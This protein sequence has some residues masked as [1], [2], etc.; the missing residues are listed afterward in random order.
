[1]NS[2]NATTNNNYHLTGTANADLCSR[3]SDYSFGDGTIFA[4]RPLHRPTF[5][6]V[7]AQQRD[8]TSK[9]SAE[10][11]S[12]YDA[13]RSKFYKNFVKDAKIV[14]RCNFSFNL[15]D[16][17]FNSLRLPFKEFSTG[18]ILLNDGSM[19]PTR[20]TFRYST[21]RGGHHNCLKGL[22]GTKE[23]QAYQICCQLYDSFNVGFQADKETSEGQMTQESVK[24]G[25][26][27]ITRDE[28]EETSGATTDPLRILGDLCNTEEDYTFPQM[29]DRFQLLDNFKVN[30]SK[31]NKVY[32]L[33]NALY[34]TDYA[35]NI[36]PFRQFIY[37]DLDIEIRV[38]VNAPK[39][40]C[41]KLII[42]S[43][44]DPYEN[45][46]DLSCTP[47][48]MLQRD[49]VIIDLSGNNQAVLR[50]PNQYRRS[51]VRTYRHTGSNTG[52]ST[53]EYASLQISSLS[54]YNSTTGQPTNVPVQVF[55]RFLKCDFAAM[56][57]GVEVKPQMDVVGDLISLGTTLFPEAKP[58][59][60]ILK[61]TG[62]IKNHDKPYL[63]NTNCVVP[64]PR[65]NFTAGKGVSD[66]IPLFLNPACTVT[67]L[68]DYQNSADPESVLD[69]AR[70]W[71]LEQRFRWTTAKAAGASLTSWAISPTNN[72][73]QLVADEEYTTIQT[74]PNP[75][76]FISSMFNFW[77]GTIEGR[78]DF[79]SNAFHTGTVQVEIAFNRQNEQ[80]SQLAATY[81]KTFDLG[82]QKSFEFTIPYIYDT[83]WR[84]TNIPVEEHYFWNENVMTI[85]PSVSI[86]RVVGGFNQLQPSAL[87]ERIRAYVNVS[88]INPLTPVSTAPSNI[89]CLFF[90]RAGQDYRLHS[91][92]PNQFH[93]CGRNKDQ[94][95]TMGLF[96]RFGI[97]SRSQ[98]SDPRIG[99]AWDVQGKNL[100]VQKD[101]N[102]REGVGRLRNLNLGST[103]KMIYIQ[104][105]PEPS[106]PTSDFTAG[107]A[108]R[109]FHT[110]DLQLNLKDIIRRPILLGQYK[111]PK[112]LD[113]VAID[114]GQD[115]LPKFDCS[116][117]QSFW[118]PCEVPNHYDALVPHTRTPFSPFASIMTLFRHWRG[119]L[120]YTFVFKTNSSKPIYCSYV[121][122]TG[123][124]QFGSRQTIVGIDS[125]YVTRKDTTKTDNAKPWVSDFRMHAETGLATEMCIP[126]VNPTLA[127]R[128][129]FDTTLNKCVTSKRLRNAS[130]AHHVLGREESS[131]I[132]GHIVL[133]CEDETEM[134]VFI[135][136]GDD[137]TPI[138]FIGCI[139][140]HQYAQGLPSDDLTQGGDS[141]S[142]TLG[143][144]FRLKSLSLTA[145]GTK[146]LN[147]EIASYLANNEV[148]VQGDNVSEIAVRAGLSG[149]AATIPTASA[150]IAT[151]GLRSKGEATLEKAGKTMDNISEAL[152]DFKDK[153]GSTLEW[154]KEALHKAGNTLG[155]FLSLENNMIVSFLFDLIIT[156][157]DFNASTI[158]LQTIKYLA[159]F[160]GKGFESVVKFAPTLTAWVREFFGQTA[161]E[162]NSA[163]SS[164]IPISLFGIVVGIVGT[165]FGV[166][167]KIHQKKFVDF[168]SGLTDRMTDPRGLSYFPA[169]VNF[170]D[171]IFTTLKGA[172]MYLLGYVEPESVLRDDLAKQI[173]QIE[174]FIHDVELITNP[175]NKSLLRRADVK[176][177]MWKAHVRAVQLKKHLSLTGPNVIAGR[178]INYCN[179]MLKF[180]SNNFALFSACPVRYEPYVICIEG[181]SNIG[182]SFIAG[183]L[184]LELLKAIRYPMD[185]SNPVYTRTPGLKHWDGFQNQPVILYDDWLNLNDPEQAT[186]QIAEL[187]ALKSKS[188]FV[189][190]MA[191][192]T[193]K[194]M[195]S[196]PRFVLLLTNN[197][198]PGSTLSSIANHEDA[199]YRRRN[200]LIYAR[201]K[202]EYITKDLR[203]LTEEESRKFVHLEFGFKDPLN[204]TLINDAQEYFSYEEILEKI[205]EKVVKYNDEEIEHVRR[206]L[207]DIREFA[208]QTTIMDDPTDVLNFFVAEQDVRCDQENPFGLYSSERLT[209]EMDRIIST[210]TLPEA[211]IALPEGPWSDF[212]DWISGKWTSWSLPRSAC[213]HCGEEK[214]IL[215]NNLDPEFKKEYNHK[216]D[217]NLGHM[218][219]LSCMQDGTCCVLCPPTASKFWR[220][221][222]CSFIKIA[223]LKR[224]SRVTY[225][226]LMDDITKLPTEIKLT[227]GLS[228]LATVSCLFKKFDM[229]LDSHN[230]YW[231]SFYS[232]L[233]NATSVTGNGNTFYMTQFTR[234]IEEK[235]EATVQGE[236]TV[237]VEFHH[238]NF[239]KMKQLCQ[240][241]HSTDCLHRIL[242][243]LEPYEAIYLDG[244]WKWESKCS[245]TAGMEVCVPAVRCEGLPCCLGDSV[246]WD[247]YKAFCERH[248]EFTKDR[249]VQLIRQLLS[250]A[251]FTV[252]DLE[253]YQSEVPFFS[254]EK[255]IRSR[256]LGKLEPTVQLASATS[257][258]SGLKNWM[259]N[260][261]EWVKKIL[262][263]VAI[264]G[265]VIGILAGAIK[266]YHTCS[267][268][269]E[270][271]LS[272]GSYQ[273]RHFLKKS[274]EVK[275]GSNPKNDS[276]KPESL[277]QMKTKMLEKVHK[278]YFNIEVSCGGKVATTMGCCGV[279][280]RDALMPRHYYNRIKNYALQSD[281]K[282]TLKPAHY[283]T[284]SVDYKFD[285]LDFKVSESADI[286][287][288]TVPKTMPTFC[289]L[290]GYMAKDKDLSEP[291]TNKGYMLRQKSA[292]S[293]HVTLIELKLYGFEKETSI[294]GGGE[295]FNAIDSLTYNYSS[296]GACG[297]LVFRENS[298]RPILGMHFAGT[299]GLSFSTKGFAVILTQEMFK[300][301]ELTP[302]YDDEEIELAPPEEAR[303][304]LEEKVSVQ[305]LGT[306]SKSVH[307]PSKSKILPSKIQHLLPAPKTLPGFLDPK[308][309]DYPHEKSPLILGCEKHGL[310]TSNFTT[311]EVDEVRDVLW[312]LKYRAMSPLVIQPKRLTLRQAIV[313]LDQPGYAPLHLNTS[314]GFPYSVESNLTQKK[315]YI[316]VQR[317][318]QGEVLDVLVSRKVVEDLQR[319]T[320]LRQSGIIPFLPY[321]DELKDERRK[322]DK[323][324]KPGSTRIFCMSSIL[325][326]IP[327]R[328]NFLHFA[329]AYSEGRLNLCHGVGM[330]RDGP[331]WGKLVRYLHEVSDNIVTLDY[332]NFGPGYNAM[333][334]AAGHDI[335]TKWTTLYVEGIN[336]TELAVLGEE[337]YNSKHIMSNLIYRQVSGGPSGDALTVVKNG[338]VNELYIL[339]AWKALM[340]DWCNE[341]DRALYPSFYDLTR[342]VVYGDDLIMSVDD[343]IKDLFNG[344]TIKQ[345]FATYGITATDAAKTGEDTAYT[346]IREA[347]FLKSGFEHHPYHRGEWL[348]PLDETSIEETAKWIHQ[349]ANHDDATTENA[350][351][352]LRNAFGHGPSYFTAWRDKL[353]EC[354]IKM[355]LK[356]IYLT[357]RE[358]DRKFF[359][360]CYKN[361]TIN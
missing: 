294:S 230:Y 301:I 248:H 214:L 157:K 209:R 222:K 276:A 34:A 52:V 224:R 146:K 333:V 73:I 188:D 337:H 112:A 178:I 109:T 278:N 161:I 359:P 286:A 288:F 15:F 154:I 16:A 179:D 38:V 186:T 92:L 127:V 183:K 315:S 216:N 231:P 2:Q 355:D 30:N 305:N 151:K 114:Y 302:H 307:I 45:F 165:F 207:R 175:A 347:T 115:T 334:N 89:E 284:I 357:W 299:G 199:I 225:K 96:P 56:S 44:P 83:P 204:A 360:A 82:D 95:P 81:T 126:S 60:R 193:D 33:P 18:A 88:V 8:F 259:A 66:N 312:S 17:W 19:S 194:G 257:W 26:T 147:L 318:E 57:F 23:D 172:L 313:G 324:L 263:A 331:E 247:T 327:S 245:K 213:Q 117:V 330:S 13:F 110:T 297:S 12:L 177:K 220:V 326:S 135:S 235:S 35:S 107:P 116:V 308:D 306:Y 211:N 229:H 99:K 260:W 121:P 9:P 120:C 21:R 300:D 25:N 74:T 242:V 180:S 317:D 311:S 293:A 43:F 217:S 246:T 271:I 113:K 343:S 169:A 283:A 155:E 203:T 215:L 184:S 49:H 228:V 158:A 51:Y 14:P 67:Q 125:Y 105:D 39:F 233:P 139:E 206:A 61:R 100:L 153:M 133:Q 267:R 349:C 86:A 94:S 321:I 279:Q 47:E 6:K 123:I 77:G 340:S 111:I 32:K 200:L 202:T 41:G 261:P 238:E 166:Q 244:W 59:E 102:S 264:G 346:S 274:R 69:I 128:V 87:T 345:F 208:G 65:L 277:E 234:N 329:A 152:A 322:L 24:A 181:E 170:V 196:N 71:G 173:P 48:S 138:D 291:L 314:M 356:P 40:G 149:L 348:S 339:L 141:K 189:P 269:V 10:Q 266:L 292:A 227:L 295:N 1:M 223:E 3:I 195:R 280:G 192:L 320:E 106:D 162:Q 289:N 303:M 22:G 254:R 310:L 142:P 273:T 287:V 210:L 4:G 31:F 201:R 63:G 134:D 68:G 159:L 50:I 119:S 197:A 143:G 130:N 76:K 350:E 129:P 137:F 156:I 124:Y 272:S 252:M 27:I 219:C 268:P 354:L 187:Y 253:R 325:T 316:E 85:G 80:T 281:I 212:L 191:D 240:E 218:I 70:I 309:P 344:I 72:N 205:Y 132:S 336:E 29:T 7:G 148:Y 262:K 55:Y 167:N 251:V 270:Q 174:E 275:R 140:Y 46:A 304:V 101:W 108:F 338:L 358:L 258:L 335:I 342:L 323:R 145:K 75:L 190:P 28:A 164:K 131:A 168:K 353:N 256:D 53:A 104:G 136:A 226:R 160:F 64:Q 221:T 361:E 11:T 118:L 176:T 198:F 36:L 93:I 5:S 236:S 352:S 232:T 237:G 171:T 249:R 97:D 296:D 290:I 58:L 62:I 298:T 78:I 20:Y 255:T 239:E 332:S 185:G 103:N 90:I 285:E 91:L 144:Y 319:T 341:Q 328:Q 182:K 163:P 241:V 37:A 79:V 250:S 42:S 265:V 282:F 150:W 351:A 243:E 98:E 122:N 84:R 54:N